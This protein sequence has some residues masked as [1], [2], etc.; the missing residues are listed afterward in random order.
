MLSGILVD[1]PLSYRATA[2]LQY[3]ARQ[4]AVGTWPIAPDARRAVSDHY[5]CQLTPGLLPNKLPFR[6]IV[7]SWM[8]SGRSDV[9]IAR[10]QYLTADDRFLCSAVAGSSVDLHVFTE[11]SFLPDQRLRLLETASACL[12]L[13]GS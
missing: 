11:V 8:L 2:E 3:P 12:A 9:L 5:D 10:G 13:I 4:I 7:R 1:C 6:K